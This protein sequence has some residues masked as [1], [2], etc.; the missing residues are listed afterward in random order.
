[1]DT[2]QWT[3][4]ASIVVGLAGALIGLAGALVVLF[5]RGATLAQTV[6][7]ALTESEERLRNENAGGSVRRSKD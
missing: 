6:V 2:T 1:M 3:E 5:W 7:R 4:V